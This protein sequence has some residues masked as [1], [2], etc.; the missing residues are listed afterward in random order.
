VHGVAGNAVTDG[1]GT[2]P[3][4]HGVLGDS[5][6]DE[7]TP[8][9]PATAAFTDDSAAPD[10]LTVTAGAYKVVFLS[11]PFEAYGTAT[12]KAALMKRA[13]AYFG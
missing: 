3:L 11:F 9:A 13:L 10:G 8:I 5:Y 2:I 6:E 1:I 12:D 7:V 4:D